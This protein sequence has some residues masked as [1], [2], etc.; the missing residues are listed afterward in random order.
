MY[1]Y[2]M[3]LRALAVAVVVDAFDAFD[4][5]SSAVPPEQVFEISCAAD[6][7]RA[8]SAGPQTGRHH[9]FAYATLLGATPRRQD[10]IG[11]LINVL[12][13]ATELRRLGST[14]AFVLMVDILGQGKLD[15]SYKTGRL[16]EEGLVV[17]HGLHLAYLREP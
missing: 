17:E 4:A 1:S 11:A 15:E 14:A 8:V 7:Q 9:R 6:H 16:A 12:V 5:S 13:A 2:D 3:R 10:Y